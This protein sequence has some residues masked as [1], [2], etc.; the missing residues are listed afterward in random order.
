MLRSHRPGQDTDVGSV[1]IFGD[2]SD[3]VFE[4]DELYRPTETALPIDREGRSL[5]ACSG[6]YV[7]NRI[8]SSNGLRLP[9]STSSG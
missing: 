5:V 2:E 9:S 7:V 4:P 6:I 8:T 1:S 3:R